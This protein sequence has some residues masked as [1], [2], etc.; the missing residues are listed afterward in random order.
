MCLI[1]LFYRTHS[2]VAAAA[3]VAALV[4]AAAAAA[5]RAVQWRKGW[6]LSPIQWELA[7]LGSDLISDTLLFN[8]M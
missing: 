4:A 3:A 2:L 1:L 8:S 5:A 6:R 7:V